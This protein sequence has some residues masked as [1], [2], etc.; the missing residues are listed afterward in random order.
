MKNEGCVAFILI[1][2][3]IAIFAASGYLAWQAL[4]PSNFIQ[5]IIFLVLWYLIN[6]Y[7]SIIVTGII[8][9]LIDEM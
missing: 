6:R 2:A 1:V 8:V 9:G 5:V 3:N 7:L 4:T